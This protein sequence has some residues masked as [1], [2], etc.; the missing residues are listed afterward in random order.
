[1]RQARSL[2]GNFLLLSAVTIGLAAAARA[3]A[4][5]DAD[6]PGGYYF[7]NAYRACLPYGY[8]YAPGDSAPGYYSYDPG[9]AYAPYYGQYFVFVPRHD[10]DHDRDR[11]RDH[12]PFRH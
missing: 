8:V 5:G 11:R 7:D 10:R 4:L 6:C 1:M 9:Y 12:D 3:Q 2:I